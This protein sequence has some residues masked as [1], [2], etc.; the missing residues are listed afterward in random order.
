MEIDGQF[1][2]ELAEKIVDMLHKVT[3]GNVNFMDM[4]GVIIATKQ[5]ERLGTVHEAAKRIM[6]G[7]V[8]EFAISVESTQKLKGVLPGYN[9]VVL[10]KGDRLGCIGLSGDPE[11]MRPLQQLAANIVREEYDK[12]LISKTKQDILEKV[13][14]EIEEMSA[15]IEQITAGS[16]ESFNHSKQIEDMANRAEKY[17]ENI[18]K[19]L[20]TI[21]NIADQTKLLG[22]NAE[23]QQ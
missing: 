16:L 22:L 20:N 14:G 4:D 10:Y 1:P 5:P 12:F 7:E 17:L 9:G 21:K 18:N 6:S 8:D 13:A 23:Y 15:A 19:V 11:K 3:G 2:V